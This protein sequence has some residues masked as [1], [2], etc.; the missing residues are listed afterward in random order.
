MRSSHS[1]S[2]LLGTPQGGVLSLFLF[3]ILM[4]RL[5]T[6]LP[7]IPG[8]TITCYADDICVHSTSPRDLQ[9]FLASS[10][11]PPLT[12]VSLSL[13]IGAGYFPAALLP[14]CQTSPLEGLSFPCVPSILTLAHLS[15]SQ[16]SSPP[17][18]RPILPPM[19]CWIASR[20]GFNLSSGSL[21]T[22]RASPFLW[23]G[24]YILL[25]FALLLITSPLPWY[26]FPELL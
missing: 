18:V 24:P 6:A 22:L 11:C 9:L 23:P 15:R 5:L 10:P 12:V 25:S 21:T 1:R 19:T 7:D 3:N 4:H 8:I 17:G 14:L 13:L 26:N 2:F 16:Q 20:D